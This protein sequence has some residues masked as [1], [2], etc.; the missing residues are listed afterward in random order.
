MHVLITLAVAI[1]IALS[2]K[3]VRTYVGVKLGL[4]EAKGSAFIKIAEAEAKELEVRGRIIA[5][6]ETTKAKSKVVSELHDAATLAHAGA[7]KLKADYDA[8]LARL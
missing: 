7:D 4:I 8:V 2:F 1:V 3:K 5:I 6:N